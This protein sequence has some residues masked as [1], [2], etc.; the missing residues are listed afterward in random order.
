MDKIRIKNM[1]FFAY[2]GILPSEAV[3]GQ[4]F[5]VDLE[6][7]GDWS[8]AGNSNNIDD[9][10][11]YENL[12]EVVKEIVKGKRFNLLEALSEEVCSQI[13]MRYSLTKKVKLSIR[14]P[15]V[16]INGILDYVE[17]EIERGR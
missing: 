16:P 10:I 2:H 6:V 17:V 14:K 5:E 11:N 1:Q 7:K 9:A 4:L 15:N 3:T 13:L 12:Y 8:V